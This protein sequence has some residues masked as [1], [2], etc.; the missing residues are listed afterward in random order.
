MTDIVWGLHDGPAL[1]SLAGG[2]ALWASV[3]EGR[4]TRAESTRDLLHIQPKLQH[5]CFSSFWPCL[6]ARA[7]TPILDLFFIIHREPTV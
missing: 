5:P 4:A 7:F 1:S 2:F 3:S 6:I